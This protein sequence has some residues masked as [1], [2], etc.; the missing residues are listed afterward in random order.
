MDKEIL[1]VLKYTN[2]DDKILLNTI[3]LLEYQVESQSKDVIGSAKNEI[4]GLMFILNKH[5]DIL[6]TYIPPNV[7]KQFMIVW[8]CIVHKKK[9]SKI[10]IKK[11]ELQIDENIINYLYNCVKNPNIKYAAVLVSIQYHTCKESE[12]KAHANL[13]IYNKMTHTIERFD[14][15]GAFRKV[16]DNKRLDKQLS[17]YFKKYNIKYKSPDDYCPRI[18]FQKLQGKEKQFKHGLCAA[19]TLWFLD[20]KLSNSHINDSKT[21]INLALEK[22]K[23]SSSLTDFILNYIRYILRY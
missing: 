23:T 5:K 16:Y 6:C 1:E 19:W 7:Y 22:L 11:R 12:V 2:K 10:G 13:L 14:P 17:E 4:N 18:S 20:F 3:N 8:T 21:L 15:I 9:G